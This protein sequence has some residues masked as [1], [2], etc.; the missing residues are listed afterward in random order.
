MASIQWAYANGSCWVPLDQ[1]A[2]SDIEALW[3]RNASYWIR[4]TSLSRTSPVYVDISQMV[5]LCDGIAYT[6]VR[7][8]V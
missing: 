8:I 2:Q 7:S 4:C 5:M 1:N 6:I 3:K